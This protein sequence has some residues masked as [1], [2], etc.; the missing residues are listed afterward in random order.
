MDR[1]FL[2]SGI[3]YLDACAEG[4]GCKDQVALITPRWP[5]QQKP[6]EG[7]GAGLLPPERMI[8]IRIRIGTRA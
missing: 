2:E 5:G 1:R 7:N 4:G 8:T 6:G 3:S